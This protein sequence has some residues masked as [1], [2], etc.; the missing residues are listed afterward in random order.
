M[1]RFIKFKG[2]LNN[3][4]LKNFKLM[5]EIVIILIM[6][7]VWKEFKD[8]IKIE[9]VNKNIR[10][11]VVSKIVLVLFSFFDFLVIFN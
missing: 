9:I 10:G 4:K 11:I 2:Y 5:V 1:I 3:Y 7:V 6:V 8:K